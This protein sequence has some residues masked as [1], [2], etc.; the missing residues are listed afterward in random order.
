MHNLRR[1]YPVTARF[2][3]L[4]EATR[5]E[6][7]QYLFESD[8]DGKPYPRDQRALVY[9]RAKNVNNFRPFGTELDVYADG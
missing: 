6:L 1:N 3:W 9:Q 7:R 2:R 8:E 4:F 5:P